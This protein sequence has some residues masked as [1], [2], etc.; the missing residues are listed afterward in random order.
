MRQQGDIRQRQ[1][2]FRHLRL[3]IEHVETGSPQ[4][5]AFKRLKQ[6]VLINAGAAPDIDE[7]ALR[8]KRR[9]DFGVDCLM[10]F[11]RTGHDADQDIDSFRHLLQRTV[12]GIGEAI[13]L[14]A[15]VVADLHLEGLQPL[16]DFLADAAHAEQ[17]N[18]AAAK[19][20]GREGKRPFAN[21]FAVTQPG[22]GLIEPAH[23]V[24][25][26]RNRRIGHLVVQHIRRIR[27]HDA[28]RGGMF[29]IHA[30]I[31]HTEIG[32]DLQLRQRI[33]PFGVDDAGN[34]DGID[35][36][37][38]TLRQNRLGAGRHCH[39]LDLAFEAFKNARV[40]L[41]GNENDG[42]FVRHERIFLLITF[43]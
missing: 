17:A 3:G 6:R 28:A 36:L 31:T 18:L 19:R 24:D 1:E 11:R 2:G 9:Q 41:A 21:P 15:G 34:G 39:D 20:E 23:G 42:L 33:D 25:Q 35:A 30:I 43:R 38:R 14:A 8:P 40:Y 27:H 13:P 26:K 32:D 7:H 10:R 4:S 16:G 5:T 29:G 22:F 37:R 12:I